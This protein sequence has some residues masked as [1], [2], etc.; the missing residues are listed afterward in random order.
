MQQ[1]LEIY[2]LFSIPSH[3]SM[4]SLTERTILPTMRI[5]IDIDAIIAEIFNTIM[6]VILV[7]L[8]MLFQ[9]LPHRIY[10]RIS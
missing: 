1:P 4:I 10:D 3:I 5:P 8:A 6:V 2:L 9:E 7:L